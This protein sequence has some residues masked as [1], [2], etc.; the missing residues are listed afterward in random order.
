MAGEPVSSGPE[1]TAPMEPGISEPFTLAYNESR[2]YDP[3]TKQ[4]VLHLEYLSD[5]ST[6]YLLRFTRYV[7]LAAIGVL[8]WEFWIKETQPE[9][10]LLQNDE[11]IIVNLVVSSC[12]LALLLGTAGFFLWA[13]WRTWAQGLVWDIHRKRVVI[14]YSL[15]L[16]VQICNLVFYLVP[17]AVAYANERCGWY[18]TPVHVSGALRWTCWN[19]VRVHVCRYLQ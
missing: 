15:E 18:L 12:C 13:M 3:N 14:T 19:T 10:E 7:V 17:N 11:L 5:R 4:V 9:K 1:G 8:S 6:K 2:P 16:C